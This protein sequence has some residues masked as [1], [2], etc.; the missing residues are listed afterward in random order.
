MTKCL[1]GTSCAVA[2]ARFRDDA[3]P[4]RETHE[5]AVPL[6]IFLPGVMQVEENARFAEQLVPFAPRWR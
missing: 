6:E 2:G 5:H 1:P 4:V 3:A